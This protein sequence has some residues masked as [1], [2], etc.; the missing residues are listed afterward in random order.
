MLHVVLPG[1]ATQEVAVA[2]EP[3]ETIRQLQALVLQK[4]TGAGGDPRESLMMEHVDRR[5]RATK[6]SKKTTLAMIKLASK[7]RVLPKRTRQAPSGRVSGYASVSQRDSPVGRAK[8]LTS[9]EE[10][11]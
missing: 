2:L 5:G 3:V 10:M 7:L 1:G 4:W 8:M 9:I 11:E 6:V